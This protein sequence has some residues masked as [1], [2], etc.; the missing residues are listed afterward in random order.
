MDFR[1]QYDSSPV[2]KIVGDLYPFWSNY[3]EHKELISTV[4]LMINAGSR[5]KNIDRV[6]GNGSYF[7]L[8][9]DFAETT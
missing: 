5:Y 9:K 8:G 4:S 6:L 3:H 1:K 7:V 2:E